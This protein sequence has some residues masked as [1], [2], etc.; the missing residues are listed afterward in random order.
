[1]PR[2]YI[3]VNPE[4]NVATALRN[5]E[6]GVCVRVETGA[7]AGDV[8]L[9]QRILFGHKFALKDIEPGEPIVKYDEVI[10]VAVRRIMK[11]EHT[12]IHNVEGLRGRG[13]K[14]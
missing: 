2:S 14:E 11:G 9:C 8:T 12:H 1:M 13:D 3:V 5:L 10:G 7:Y 6:Q 4:D